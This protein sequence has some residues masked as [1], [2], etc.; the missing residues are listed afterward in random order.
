MR[1]RWI[2]WREGTEKARRRR[3]RRPKAGKHPLKATTYYRE[4]VVRR[5]PYLSDSL[6]ESVIRRPH[7]RHIQSDGRIRIWA[8]VESLK[9]TMVAGGAARGWRNDSQC[10]HRP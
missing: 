2:S 1:R 6:V 5:R 10:I 3:R 7:V 8:R 9:R 4:L